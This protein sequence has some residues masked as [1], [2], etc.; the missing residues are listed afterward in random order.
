MNNASYHSICI[1]GQSPFVIHTSCSGTFFEPLLLLA[2]A[3]RPPGA[4]ILLAVGTP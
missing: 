3:F 1:E 2:P 4:Q